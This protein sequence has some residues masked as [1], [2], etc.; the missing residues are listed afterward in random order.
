MN[1]PVTHVGTRLMA[2]WPTTAIR[3]RQFRPGRLAAGDARCMVGGHAHGAC[4]H[5]LV[6]ACVSQRREDPC[7]P[8]RTSSHRGWLWASLTRIP[9]CHTAHTWGGSWRR[10]CT[11]CAH[12]TLTQS[13]TRI[14][15]CSNPE[16]CQV[17]HERLKMST[18]VGGGLQCVSHC[19][20]PHA[21]S[22]RKESCSFPAVLCD[23]CQ[24]E[25]CNMLAKYAVSL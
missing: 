12:A 22:A 2:C 16:H 18:Q 9:R 17:D 10:P 6:C 25:G 23:P 1:Y 15:C 11:P 20:G 4:S 5:A 7:G 8:C 14:H 13:S 19:T 21:E 24:C 3:A